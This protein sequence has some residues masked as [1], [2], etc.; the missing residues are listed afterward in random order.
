MRHH[1]GGKSD[2][3]TETFGT[4]DDFSDPDGIAVLS[5]WQAQSK[6]REQMVRRA[7]A[8]ATTDVQR[9]VASSIEAYVEFLQSNR[10]SGREARYAA[11]AFILPVLGKIKL[12]ELTAIQVRKWHANL[13]KAQARVRTAKGSEQKFRDNEED[14]D[15]ERRRKSTANRILTILKGALNRSWRDGHVANDRAWRRVEPFKNAD[16][17]RVRYLS[18]DETTRFLNVAGEDFRK[19]VRGALESG[20]RYGELCDFL[21]ADFNPDAGTLTVPD[22]KG[23]KPRH[24]VL[25]DDGIEFFDQL[26]A[27]RGGSEPMFLKGDGAR[28]LSDHQAEPMREANN[29]A[30][31]SPPINFHGLRHTWASHAVM[32]GM[33]LI[34]VAKNL[35]HST[36]RMVEKHY[37]HL[38]P[39]YVAQAVRAHAP[40]FGAENTQSNVRKLRRKPA[41]SS[42]NAE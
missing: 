10:K 5:F 18:L 40:R 8:G 17:A 14:P 33:P 36:T 26:T 34:V 13:A 27:G 12:D 42:T 16:S 15:R 1:L 4:A 2:Y 9:T 7:H 19:L 23:G 29:R 25:S 11:D 20:A 28:W 6:A 37:G 22:P 35:G 39:S 24:I 38:A 32:N 21:V 3:A 31:I 41:P 30:K